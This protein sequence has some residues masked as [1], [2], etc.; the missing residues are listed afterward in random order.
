MARESLDDSTLD[1]FFKGEEGTSQ[2]Q[3]KQDLISKKNP[4]IDGQPIKTTELVF[5]SKDKQGMPFWR[6]QQLRLIDQIKTALDE[7]TFNELVSLA[8]SG[9]IEELKKH[10]THHLGS[11]IE[12]ALNNQQGTVSVQEIISMLN[13]K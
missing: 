10:I 7:A 5:V 12:N 6:L 2:K 8:L 1:T 9:N 13:E 3:D 4:L 11:K